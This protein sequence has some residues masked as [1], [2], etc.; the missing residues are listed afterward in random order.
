VRSA[1]FLALAVL[2][3]SGC[4]PHP[5]MPVLGTVPDFSLTDQEGREFRP[6]SVP[7]TVWIVDFIYTNCPGPCPLMSERMKRIARELQSDPA[8]HCLSFSVDPARDTPNA[9]NQYAR[10][11]RAESKQWTFLTGDAKTLDRLDWDVF[12]LG[13]LT[14]DFNHSTRFVLVDK[15]RQ[16][17]AYY[18]MSDDDMIAHI[19]RDARYFARE[20]P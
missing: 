9:L 10:R 12:K 19:V 13:H 1:A 18:R 17:R 6:S 20:K 7:G 3:A 11:Y 8:I 5:E 14:P 15:Q 2:L 4:A 16:I